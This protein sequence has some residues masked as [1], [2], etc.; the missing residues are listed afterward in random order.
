MRQPLPKEPAKRLKRLSVKLICFVIPNRDRQ[1]M[2]VFIAFFVAALFVIA[3]SA[4]AASFLVC[5]TPPTPPIPITLEEYIVGY[6]L[7]VLDSDTKQHAQYMVKGASTKIY[8][9]PNVDYTHHYA[10]IVQSIGP[11]GLRSYPTKNSLALYDP[12]NPPPAIN[13]P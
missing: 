12:A 2:K 6:S 3:P 8:T 4:S 5:W 7:T 11:T 13:C 10:V 9:V 1:K